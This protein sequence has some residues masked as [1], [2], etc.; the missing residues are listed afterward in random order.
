MRATTDLP[1]SLGQSRLASA[2]ERIGSQEHDLGAAKAPGETSGPSLFS[3]YR[4][5]VR[6]YT[7]GMT[8]RISKALVVAIALIIGFVRLDV[9]VAVSTGDIPGLPLPATALVGEVGGETVDLVYSI[10]VE[11]GTSLLLTLRGSEGA[12]LGLYVFERDANSVLSGTPLASSAQPGAE[13]SI[14]LLFFEESQ[15]YINING[16][17]V[18]RPYAFQ[19]ITS[20]VVD[21]TP[22]VVRIAAA[23]KTGTGSNACV[24]VEA[25]D[26][27]SGIQSIAVNVAGTVG[28][29]EWRA[30]RGSGRYCADLDLGEGRFQLRVSVR[31]TLGMITSVDAGEVRID[32]RAPTV[33]LGRPMNGVLLDP[34]GSIA[35]GFS[36]PIWFVGPRRSG[37]SVITQTGQTLVG[38]VEL[39]VDRKGARWIPS[40][41]IPVGTLIVAMLAQ[42][43]DAAGNITTSNEP[44]IATRKQRTNLDIALMRSTQKRVYLRATGSRNLS[45]STVN[46]EVRFGRSWVPLRTVVIGSAGTD[47]SVLRS[48]WRQVRV[49][50]QGSELL[51]ASN[52]ESP[53]FN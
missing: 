12:E 26:R 2:K 42:V 19:L 5:E 47:F 35:F 22:P 38:T 48:D 52:A 30:Y 33:T 34:K 28:P 23:D 43:R 24:R 27:I 15:I 46:V 9:V 1:R 14:A 11:A 17:N 7:H 13:Q 4:Y 44:H 32:N 21:R 6:P 39:S 16:R 10:N 50:W 41:A 51:H 40:E 3:T 53:I 31:N 49:V 36:E 45:G 18:D 29:L 8:S 37:I 25:F 20:V